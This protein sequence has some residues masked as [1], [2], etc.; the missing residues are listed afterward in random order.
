MNLTKEDIDKVRRIEGFPNAKDVDII[1]ISIPPYYSACPNPFIKDFI[2]KNGHKYDPISDE[3]HCHPFTT[4]VSEGKHDSLYMAHSYHTKVPYKAIMRYILHYTKPGDIILDGFGGSG[5]TGV[6][7]LMCGCPDAE[8]KLKIGKDMPNIVWGRRNAIICDLSPEAAFI[9][10]NYNTEVNIQKFNEMAKQIID[11]VKKDCS[12]MYSTFHDKKYNGIGDINYT[13]WSDV[14]ICP[15][16]GKELV[17]WDIAVGEN[18][19]VEES[20]ICS[21]CGVT[22]N[23]NMC[24]RA[25]ESKIEKNGEISIFAKQV[26]VKIFYSY[27]GKRFSKNIDE[28]DKNNIDKIV[29]NGCSYWY[30]EDEL[31]KGY[32]T[33]Q[34][35][36]SHGF[37]RINHF[38]TERNLYVLSKCHDLI[39]KSEDKRIK[40]MLKFWFSSIYSRSHK[41]NRY[42]P[43]HNR[44][45]GPLS[46]TLYVP[47]FQAEINIINL[48][49]DK[50]K[51]VSEIGQIKGNSIVSTQSTTNLS[52]I[53][54]NSCDYIF[55]DPPFGDNLNYSELN[56][57]WEGWLKVKTNNTKEAI[58]NSVQGKNLVDY[59]RLMEQCF[60]EYYRVLKPNRWITIEFHNS[61]NAVWN[62][63]QESLQKVGFV[64]ADVRT[65]DKQKGTTKQLSMTSIVK[66]DLVISAYKPISANIY[67]IGLKESPDLAWQFVR[68]HLENLPV[69]VMNSG[70]IEILSERQNYLLFDRLVA[71]FIMKGV[72]IPMDAAEFYRGLDEKYLKRDNMYFLSDQV[73]E[74]DNARI[75]KEIE[76]IQ[77]ELFVTNEKSAISWLYQQLESPQTYAEIQPKFMQEI[78]KIDKFEIMP[79]LI[80]ILE[81]NFLRD[82]KERWYIPNMGREVDINRLRNKK[83]IKEFEGYIQTKGKLKT[84][85]TE[86]IRAGF[87]KLW[88]DKN[89]KLIVETAERLPESII[90]EDDKILMYYDISLG[91][92]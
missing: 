61:K 78:K 27:D 88:N 20:P 4:D 68:N 75:L 24:E 34:P 87:A 45:V 33:E 35:I 55:T 74:Y 12:W 54:D 5:M 81:D 14:F 60:L 69:V 62:A 89:Y 30:P 47:F 59:Q 52:N 25:K 38:Y 42:M 7:A 56:C 64:V 48:L 23:K 37:H 79:E 53:D 31:P 50:L 57:I 2:D 90:Q 1:E 84:F 13:V 91:R 51:A 15:N 63:I 16:C 66:Q 3:Y 86:A 67:N 29:S 11:E 43:N 58:V 70:K 77:F 82:E 32:N 44:H 9:A 83:L 21:S 26:P 17:L 92:I 28:I 8:T 18:G 41:L 22:I 71:F 72:A 19:E 40:L 65:L 6:A 10:G 36:R 39:E 76:P 85:R 73:N 46:G 49:E 80:E